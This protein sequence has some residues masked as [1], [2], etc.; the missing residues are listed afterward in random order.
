MSSIITHLYTY[1]GTNLSFD[2]GNYFV[3]EADGTVEVTLK[4]TKR[5]PFK[6]SLQLITINDTASKLYSV[7][8]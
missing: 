4:L 3:D 2:T 6:I 1:L 5:L 8:T 7:N